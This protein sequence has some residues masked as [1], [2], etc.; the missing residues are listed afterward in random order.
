M[1]DAKGMDAAGAMSQQAALQSTVHTCWR[2][3]R[4]LV[5]NWRKQPQS[6]KPTHIRSNTRTER[7]L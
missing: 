3:Q 1:D 6:Q 2:S 5:C 7:Q 4:P